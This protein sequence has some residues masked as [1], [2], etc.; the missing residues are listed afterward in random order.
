MPTSDTA[1]VFT[2]AGARLGLRV[3]QVSEVVPVAELN[4]VPE[5]PQVIAGFLSLAGALVPIV[6]LDQLLRLASGAEGKWN[7]EE[8]LSS[9]I[10]I[11]KTASGL[12]GWFIAE[13]ASLIRFT[14]SELVRLPQGH[15][16]NNCAEYVI[17]RTPPEP[18]IVMLEPDRV[19][20]EKERTCVE[21]IRTRMRERMTAFTSAGE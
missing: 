1:L 8:E 4:Q 21:E 5:T 6:R 12:L 11:S 16:L 2:V 3:T 13:G 15:V 7:P 10:V 17:A 19:L 20:L 9:R 18:S 14:A